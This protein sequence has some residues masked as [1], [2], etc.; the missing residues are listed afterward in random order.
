MAN[1]KEHAYGRLQE[2][3]SKAQEVRKGRGTYNRCRSKVIANVKEHAYGRLQGGLSKVQEVRGKEG[4]K[5]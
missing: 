1:V 5:Q 2:E 4:H 3:L